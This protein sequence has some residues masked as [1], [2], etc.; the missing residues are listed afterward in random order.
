MQIAIQKKPEWFRSYMTE[1]EDA[2]PL[3][4]HPSF[5]VSKEEYVKLLGTKNNLTLRKTHKVE[6]VANRLDENTVKFTSSDVNSPLNRLKINL[7][8]NNVESTYGFL[9]EYSQINQSNPDSLT[10][11]WK[12][13]Q[14]KK[15]YAKG[16]GG[17]LEKLAVGRLDSGKQGIIYYDLK[18]SMNNIQKVEHEF[19]FFDLP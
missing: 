10:G 11:A 8:K 13:V 6:I 14:W 5:G 15:E 9:D 2:R 3:P 12:G 19:V 4:Y 7:R 17:I 1:H 18:Y 16:S